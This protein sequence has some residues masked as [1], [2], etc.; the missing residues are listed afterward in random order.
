MPSSAQCNHSTLHNEGVPPINITK[1][2]IRNTTNTPKQYKPHYENNWWSRVLT[3]F[4][5]STCAHFWSNLSTTAAWPPSD[6]HINAEHPAFVAQNFMRVHHHEP[7]NELTLFCRSTFAPCCSNKSTTVSWPESEA[8][9]SAVYPPCTKFGN[10]SFDITQWNTSGTYL[11]CS[12][13]PPLHYEIV[14][15]LWL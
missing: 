10:A 1:L 3:M 11:H 12:S 14:M 9:I 6:A 4:G 7:S 8:H 5:R 2:Q 15:H 13:D